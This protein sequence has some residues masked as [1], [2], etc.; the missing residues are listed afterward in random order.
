MRPIHAIQ[1]LRPMRDAAGPP[2]PGAD[3]PSL[4]AAARFGRF[5]GQ[6]ALFSGN[7]INNTPG[8]VDEIWHNLANFTPFFVPPPEQSIPP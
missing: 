6:I 1:P 5:R 7:S 3:A 8:N 2:T 4:R